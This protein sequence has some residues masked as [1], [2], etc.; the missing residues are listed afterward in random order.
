MS[1]HKNFYRP[2]T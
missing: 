2:S 1:K